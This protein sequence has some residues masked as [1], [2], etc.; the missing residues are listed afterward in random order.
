MHQPAE[1][2][3]PTFAAASKEGNDDVA[4]VEHFL[5]E[6][7]DTEP[8]DNRTERSLKLKADLLIVPIMSLTFLVA[9]MVSPVLRLSLRPQLTLYR[10]EIISATQ[11]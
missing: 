9:Y 2:N 7:D 4:H 5:T 11:R 10:T 3:V 6:R 1:E 8:A